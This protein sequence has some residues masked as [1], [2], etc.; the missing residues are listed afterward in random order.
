[1]LL[2]IGKSYNLSSSQKSIIKKKVKVVGIL[3]YNEAL[4]VAY[5]I[6]TL[7]INEKIINSDD[8]DSTYLQSLT[9][10]KCAYLE[11]DNINNETGEYLLIWDE[12]IDTNATTE[13]NVV[14]N[15]TSTI[16]I[17]PNS[18]YQI[19]EIIESI[20]TNIKELYGDEVEIN[21]KINSTSSNTSIDENTNN[22]INNLEQ[23]QE[24]L[25]EATNSLLTI[26]SLRNSSETLI[27]KINNLS[28]S[29]NLTEMAEVLDEVK[30]TVDD[31]YSAVK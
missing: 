26:V 13:L 5:N 25:K 15:L 21:T 4:K 30:T 12:I 31:I 29:S 24:L 3:D 17:N 10:Y 20:K 2:T 9:Y 6:R 1:M 28:I 27:E 11:T 19:S 22:L 16:T 8:G 18:D 23:M 7:A 14:Y